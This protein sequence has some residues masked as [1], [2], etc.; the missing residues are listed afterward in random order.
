MNSLYLFN[1]A[2][3]ADNGIGKIYPD[4]THEQLFK[5]DEPYWTPNGMRWTANGDALFMGEFIS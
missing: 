4:G 1:P 3:C 5:F 2:Y